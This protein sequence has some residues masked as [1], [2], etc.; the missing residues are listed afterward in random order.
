MK[1]KCILV[2]IC[3]MFTSSFLYAQIKISENIKESTLAKSKD[4]SLYFIDF[5]AT[6]CKPCIHVSKY[7]ESLQKQYPEDFYILSLSQESPEVVNKFLLKHKI[8][9]AVAIDYEGETFTKNNIYSLPYGILYNAHGE[10]LWE[11]HPAE[12]KYYHLDGYLSQNKKKIHVNTFFETVKY[13]Q[14][15]AKNT[16]HKMDFEY[17]SIKEYNEFS[18]FQVIDNDSYVQLNGNLQ[19]IIAYVLSSNKNQVEIPNNLNNYYSMYFKKASKSFLD[20]EKTIFKALKLKKIEIEKEGEVLFL[21]I[22]NANFWDTNQIQWEGNTQKYLI[23]DSDIQA[24]NV[25]L[26]EVAYKLSNVLEKPIVFNKEITD[27]SLHD[28]Q[29]HYKYFELMTANLYDYGL[30]IERKTT[31]YPQ[32]IITEKHSK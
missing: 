32:F 15:T 2:F 21:D 8:N 19:D 7:L 11:G 25:S 3:A 12:F 24:D 6:W 1:L 22:K 17:S 29:I 14:V 10:K 23:G 30:K 18:N 20:K 9:L 27:N 31:K 13:E 28:W 4:N 26:K 16:V 5:W